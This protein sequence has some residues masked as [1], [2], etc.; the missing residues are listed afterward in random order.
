MNEDNIRGGGVDRIIDRDSVSATG[1]GNTDGI[2]ELILRRG[3]QSDGDPIVAA[4]E[5]QIGLSKRLFDVVAALS[6]GIITLPVL[7]IVAIVIRVSGTPVLYSH[8]RVG[9][10]RKP[11]RCWKFRSMV[12]NAEVILQDLLRSDP[13]ALQEWRTNHKLRSD[14]RITRIGRFLRRSSLDELPQLW[15]VLVGDMSFVGPRPVVVDELERYGNKVQTYCSVRPGMTGLWQVS[16]RS[17]VTYS[18]RVSL[19]VLYVRRQNLRLDC[20]VVWRT[21]F[22]VIQK[23]GAH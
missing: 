22:V 16:G 21:I 13:R 1:S 6:V 8:I 4:N 3:K 12:P 23:V 5:C 20:W 15:N 11:F 2:G 9:Q 19:D 14:P 17:N 18:R 10:N 7:V